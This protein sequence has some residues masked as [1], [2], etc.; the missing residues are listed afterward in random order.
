METDRARTNKRTLKLFGLGLCVV[1]VLAIW[2]L[3]HTPEPKPAAQALATAPLPAMTEAQAKT[4]VRRLLAELD[5][6][7]N[8]AGFHDA[9]FS[10]KSMLT[11][12]AAWHKDATA[13][14]DRISADASLPAA[15]RAAPGTLLG[16]G[17]A[18]Q[19]SQGRETAKTEEGRGLVVAAVR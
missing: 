6:F 18:Y 9:G 4:E 10:G 17:L 16:L 14:R 19:Q 1:A 7:K 5:S 2:G 13:L 3:W 11:Q 15:L 8:L 12:P